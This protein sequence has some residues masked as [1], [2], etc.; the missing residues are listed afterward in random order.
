M[1]SLTDSLG[2]YIHVP[3]CAKKC[4]YCDFYSGFA[5]K[6]LLDSYTKAVIDSIKQWGGKINRPIDTVYLGGGTPSL[7]SHRL[8]S[9]LSAVRENFHICEDA[10]ITLEINPDGDVH[11]IL[12]AAKAAGV[13]RLSIGAQSGIDK[14][15]K[16]LG[17]THT[18]ADTENCVRTARALGFDNISLDIMIGLPFSD[19]NSLTE[20][21][22]FINRLSPEHISAYILKIEENTAF[23][24]DKTLIFPDDDNLADQYLEMCRFFEEKGYNHYEISNFSR[25]NFESRHNLK[26]WKQKEYLGIGPAAH[27]F[28]DGKRFFYPRD[29][30]AFLNSEE[31]LFD[32]AGGG[33]N[34]Y[35]MLNLRL[36]EGLDFEAFAKKFGALPEA[37]IKT[38]KLLENSGYLKINQKSISLTNEGML[39]SNTVILKL[40][41][42]IE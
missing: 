36:K 6:E 31:P 23:S 29:L 30:K 28:I 19:I 22:E 1:K 41:E 33:K 7:L 21:L 10:E 18:A 9:V 16:L 13:N 38:A 37:I 27:S 32:A 3:F 26:Y 5:T 8:P 14:E 15:L 40:L 35:I 2:L 12:T 24:K 34:E 25:K 39:L 17:R 20:S 42:C 4:R 11:E